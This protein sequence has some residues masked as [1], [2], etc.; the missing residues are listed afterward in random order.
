MKRAL[1]LFFLAVVPSGQIKSQ[2][3]GWVEPPDVQVEFIRR[4]RA[5]GYND[6][7]LQQIDK[8]KSSPAVAGLLP[9]ERAR[10]L[11]ALA[12]EKDPEQRP[13]LL[14][15]A[16]AELEAFIQKNPSGPQGA[17]GRLEIA[18]LAAY[19][20][21]GLLTRALREEDAAIARKA[22]QQF[23]QAGR[24]LEAAIELLADVVAKEKVDQVKQQLNQDL[25]GARFDRA[26]NY[27]DQALT[28]IDTSSDADNR[29]RAEAIDKAKRAFKQ[30]AGD[31]GS[32]GLLASAWL[33]KVNQEGQDPTEA[34]KHRQRVMV[35]TSKAAQ[36]AQR[37]ARLF[38]I[39]GILK[40]PTIKADT[41][42]KYKVI[43]DEAKKWLA[44][45]P[46]HHKTA[47]GWAVRFELAQALYH[48]AQAMTKDPKAP[49]GAAALAVLNQAQK[50]FAAIGESDSNL[51]EK[52][53]VFDVNISVMKLGDKTAVGDLKD[54]DSCYLKAQVEWSKMRTVAAAL[55]GAAPKDRDKLEAERKQHLREMLKA[56][57]RG[58]MLADAKTSPHNLDEAR[59][60]LATG[61][62]LAGDLYRA[63]VAGE[64]LGRTRPPTKRAA[65]AA[66]YAIEA[67]TGIL[68]RDSA[69]SNR[70]HFQDLAEYVLSPEMQ[71]AWAGEPV[72]AV[73]RYHLAMLYNKDN[74]YK[75]AIA[76]LNKLPPDYSGFIYA[77]GQLV[78]IAQ[79]AREK[80][81]TDEEKK[82]FADVARKAI[83][84]MGNLPQ[85]ADSGTAA[86]YFFAQLELPKFY[87][88][89][90]AAELAKNDLAKA[91]RFYNE[92]AKSI[93]GLKARLEKA[94]AKLSS[95]TRG[96]LD[97]SVEVMVKYVRLGVAGLDYRKGNYDKVL[98]TTDDVVAAVAKRGGDGRAPI[99]FKDYQ[100]T[101]DILGLAL[102]ANV[103]KG[104]LTK[105]RQILGYLERLG[106]DDG[107]G[108]AE[109]SNVLHS[110]I[111]D[112]QAQVTELKKAN[113]PVKLRATVKNFSAFIDELAKKDT[114][115]KGLELK[116]IT[117]LAKCYASLEEHAKAAN[118][119]AQIPA[120]RALDKDKPKED[121]EKEIATYWLMQI[122]YAQELRLSA[123]SK[124][125][126]G[127]AKRV[128]DKLKGH[129]NARLQIYGEVEQIHILEDSGK[130][131]L[132]LYGLAMKGWGAIM[133]NSA[134]RAK[135]P[136]DPNLKELYF[137]AY[138]G[139]AWC[140][141]KHSQTAAALT[142]GKDKDYLKMAAN[143]IVRL[144]KSVNQEGWQIV[145]H[146]FRELLTNEKKLRDEYEKLKRTTK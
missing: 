36:P 74:A 115:D 119:Y 145:G 75:E 102:R 29:K 98:M 114:K 83:L 50:H 67:Y 13:A 143:N 110:L 81:K 105:A 118:L 109:T 141:Y 8:L 72:T 69:D 46:N 58:I 128:L 10:T 73:A 44:A 48:E 80:T 111:G 90:A 28:Y 51:A 42:K 95:D 85:D 43:E 125:D 53:K 68:Q 135:M 26:S 54:F 139:N 12:R 124:E 107:G 78:F 62:L 136:D 127:K 37:L 103:Q 123:H 24:Q 97:F 101:G 94:P 2:E 7:A 65:Q 129:K 20:G 84:R 122:H 4:L 15:A 77:Q 52:A 117:F 79:E 70:Q 138:Y 34:E 5:K 49:P 14:S 88:A 1:V 126:L 121:E 91:E 92:M 140:L 71:K 9:L 108:V 6:L 134:L 16:Q 61:Y 93:T 104:N 137:N 56:L 146:R 57:G 131:G 21:Q 96:Q 86:M 60:L 120:P 38:Y 55:A 112:L 22:E 87:Y 130:F 99:R 100:V 63:A 142:K 144:E 82:A 32:V 133:S 11:L 132:P 106:G 40:N 17:Q 47:E 35:D 41:L 39:Q 45:Y 27:I 25:L 89:D 64:A 30:L 76:Q 33:V 3:G 18:R 19:L 59:Y 23:I 116:D 31:G 66:G 113:D